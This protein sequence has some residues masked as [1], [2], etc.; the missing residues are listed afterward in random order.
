MARGTARYRK[1][2][3]GH[4]YRECLVCKKIFRRF[5]CYVARPGWGHF[6]SRK[7]QGRAWR[8]F[9]VLL[10]AGRFDGLL[11]EATE[12]VAAEGR[13]EGG[14]VNLN[15]EFLLR[16]WVCNNPFLSAKGSA[17]C[18]SRPECRMMLAEIDSI[19]TL[20][21]IL[22]NMRRS[23]GRGLETPWELMELAIE[24]LPVSSEPL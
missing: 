9:S 13:K 14:G 1:G 4:V 17:R 2:E 3:V 15:S 12:A 5:K 18:C 20:E 6:C 16:C 19:M 21:F 7:C 24:Q 11:R 22:T 23:G 8:L 10:A